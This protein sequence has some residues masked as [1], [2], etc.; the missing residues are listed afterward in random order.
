MYFT[1][2]IKKKNIY[3]DVKSHAF[4]IVPLILIC[5]FPWVLKSLEFKASDMYILITVYIIR[6][7]SERYIES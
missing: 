3:A 4:F 7:N 6:K 2:R 5:L 1:I